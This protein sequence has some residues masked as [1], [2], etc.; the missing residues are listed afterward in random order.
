M[1]TNQ[2][3]ECNCVMAYCS[4]VDTIFAL[5]R[6]VIFYHVRFTVKPI[7]CLSQEPVCL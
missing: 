6:M 5:L 4:Y 7:F 2:Q 3:V 1:I